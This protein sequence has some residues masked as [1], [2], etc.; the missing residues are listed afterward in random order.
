MISKKPVVLLVTLNL[1]IVV[2][3]ILW[4]GTSDS[5][6]FSLSKIT[7]RKVEE[8]IGL[9]ED[10]K[11]CSLAIGMTTD[12]LDELE[13]VATKAETFLKALQ[14]IVTPTKF[15]EELKNPCWPRN[16]SDNFTIDKLEEEITS[17]STESQLVGETSRRLF[18]LPYFFLAGFPKCG[19]TSIH[20][21]LKRHPQIIAP[22]IK[23]P[24]WWARTPLRNMGPSYVKHISMRYLHY[25]GRAAR[26]LS[27]LPSNLTITYDGTQSTLWDSNFFS[28]IN[29]LDYCAMPSIVS[30]T[31]PSAKFIVIMRNPVTRAFSDYYYQCN[32]YRVSSWPRSMQEN[33]AK[34][35]HTS[36]LKDIAA[37]NSCLKNDIHSLQWCLGKLR[38]LPSGCGYVGERLII[39]LYYFHLQEWMTF[40]PKESFLFLRTEDIFEEPHR[41][42]TRMTDFLDV[43]PVSEDEAKQW[44][45]RVSNVH[46]ERP[47][48]EPDK[49]VMMTESKEL[50]E[51]FFAP[52]NTMLAEL[53]GDRRFL[54][55][56]V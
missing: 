22:V 33:P 8:G 54:W 50:L 55:K 27:I 47:A 5:S 17:N 56:D 3:Y 26:K 36:V 18:C 11:K 37:F 45:S 2:C 4:S 38:S 24:H 52:Y 9:V 34:Y 43:D 7:L 30:R 16:S 6:L 31:L 48:I 23:E 41:I 39:G 51:D 40:Y 19:T 29:H 20:N 25:F 12:E 32:H 1:L 53:T 15:S 10:M 13:H 42:M 35:F 46:H 21:T 49:L 14:R 44:L 28:K